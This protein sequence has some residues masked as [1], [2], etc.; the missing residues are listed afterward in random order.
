MK[1][2]D[3]VGAISHS[4]GD[5]VYMYGYGTYQGDHAPG[6]VEAPDPGGWMGEKLKQLGHKNPLIKLDD[7]NYVWG[8]ECWWG[9]EDKIKSQV[10]KYANTETVDPVERRAKAQE[11]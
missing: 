11:D 10:A 9:A 8:C 7:G 3:R 5:V 2:G 1:I 4:E 6:E